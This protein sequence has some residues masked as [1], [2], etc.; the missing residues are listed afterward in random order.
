MNNDKQIT[1]F[2]NGIARAT[3]KLEALMQAMDDHLGIAPDDVTWA[4]VGSIQNVNAK[5]DVI[6]E[7]LGITVNDPFAQEAQ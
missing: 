2:T 3:A 6:L 4:S 5:L 1:G 7:F